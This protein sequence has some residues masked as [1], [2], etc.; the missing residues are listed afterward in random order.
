[1]KLRKIIFLMSFSLYASVAFS[2]SMDRYFLSSGNLFPPM[3]KGEARNVLSEAR[4]GSFLFAP[5]PGNPDMMILSYVFF[6]TQKYNNEI[7][8]DYP[9]LETEEEV[10]AY[11]KQQASQGD[12]GHVY[13]SGGYLLKSKTGV[14]HLKLDVSG[15]MV[16]EKGMEQF[17]PITDYIASKFYLSDP[18]WNSESRQR[19]ND[20]LDHALGVMNLVGLVSHY[21]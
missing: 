16:S 9:A 17:E 20:Q 11:L 12:D 4:I 6:G 15:S 21:Y 7:S 2:S 8:E 18:F 10:F 3:T 14:R 19:A 13:R 1:M 5:D